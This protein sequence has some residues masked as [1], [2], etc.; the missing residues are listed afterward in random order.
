MQP[1]IECIP[2]F[3]EGQNQEVVDQIAA[4]IRGVEGVKLMHID[5]GYSAN[6]TVMTFAG[7]PDRVIEAAF[8]GI[9]EASERIDMSAQSG[10]HPRM[11]ATDVCPLV[12]IQGIPF[13]ALLPYAEQLGHRVGDELGIPVYFYEKSALISERHNLAFIRKGGYEGFQTKILQAKWK[14]DAGPQHFHSRAGQTVIGVRD[15]LIAYNI[16]LDTKDTSLAKDIAGE[17]RESGKT[18]Q[19]NGVK[20]R[21]AGTCKGVKAI[22]W[23]VDEFGLV[24]VSTNVTDI[25]TT[26]VHRVF[27]E[28][29]KEANKRGVEV[30][31]SEVIGMIPKKVLIAAGKY[32]GKQEN[33]SEESLI[34]E[35]IDQLGLSEF[36]LFDPY[37]KILEYQLKL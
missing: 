4:A 22:G 6:R 33:P 28:V 10:T 21:I 3:S 30:R 26:P 18:I 27:E 15:F 11:G 16:N 17:I 5:M 2:N 29:K 1:I 7:T 12:P 9:K 32:Y 35:A 24:Q 37:Q 8:R 25:E 36:D 23:Y 19:K 14:P 13:D 20:Q 31:G 34:R